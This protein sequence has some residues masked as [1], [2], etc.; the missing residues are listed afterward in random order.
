[1]PYRPE[2]KQ[3]TRE[4]IVESARQL[5]NRRGFSDV[6]IDEIMSDAGLTR[7][8]FYN[9]FD[10]KDE[11]YCEAV[12]AYTQCNPTDR[13]DGVTFDMNGSGRT[14]AH[15]LINAYLSSEHLGDIDGQC[16]MI[17]LP[18]DVARAGPEV[19]SVYQ[20]LLQGMGSMIE[21]GLKSENAQTRRRTALAITA[22]CIGSMVVA[23]TVD[24][25]E[26]A[27]E[28]REASR[29]FILNQDVWKPDTT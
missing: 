22:L 10:T 29:Q 25:E 9:H 17:S 14:L 21:E 5:F 7:G 28:M 27:N 13:W 6:S 20:R 4:R 23:R 1:M 15:E 12:A 26:F 11:L 19:R 16:P 24:D 8:G 18:S 3:E 2:H